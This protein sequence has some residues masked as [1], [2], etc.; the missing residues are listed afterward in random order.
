VKDNDGVKHGKVN[1]ALK[2][3]MKAERA[4]RGTAL[5]FL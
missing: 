5:L 4:R 3:A 1:F 2:Q